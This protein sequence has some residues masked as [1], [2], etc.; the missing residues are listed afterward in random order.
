MEQAFDGTHKRPDVRADEEPYEDLVRRLDRIPGVN[1][2]GVA[3]IL[4]EIG[5]D[6]S[7]WEDSGK[8]ASWSSQTNRHRRAV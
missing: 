7:H 5:P 4:A 6:V 8:L 3:D 1:R 2:V